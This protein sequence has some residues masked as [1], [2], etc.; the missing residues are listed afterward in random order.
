MFKDVGV[1]GAL[2]VCFLLALFCQGAL[3]LSTGV[4]YGIGGVLLIAVSVMTNFSIGSFLLFTL[5]IVHAMVGAVELGT[6]G[7]IQN[8]TGNLFTSAEGKYLFMWTSAIMFSLRFC[9]N[10]IEK[11]LGISPVGILVICAT[12]ACIGLN[13]ASNITSIGVAFLALAVYAIGKTFFWPTMLAVAS[14]R[15]PRTGA[16]A[17]SIMGG[18]GMLSA[19]M[20]GSP[21]LGYAKDRFSTEALSQSNPAALAAY[22]AEKPS[23]FLF[24]AEAAALDGTKLADAQKVAPAQRT[25]EQKAVAEASIA[26][27]RKTLKADSFIPATMAAIY[28]LLLLYF[29]TIGGYK[30]VHIGGAAG[31]KAD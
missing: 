18:I 2:I 3:G 8:I 13:L 1:L 21:G 26:G 31:Q 20:I 23:K 22:K 14:D 11:R 7:W 9:A 4:A 19:G 24:F 29:K 12:L 28:L 17:I 5:F 6:D 10:F 16:I 15:F 27:D 30:V 25:P